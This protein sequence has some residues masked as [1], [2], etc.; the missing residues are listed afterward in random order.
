MS[1]SNKRSNLYNSGI[2]SLIFER[3]EPLTRGDI[4]MAVKNNYHWTERLQEEADGG[5]APA[6][7]IR[8]PLCRRNAE[9]HRLRTDADDLPGPVGHA[10]VGSAGAHS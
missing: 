9:I 6:R 8:F 2:R 7:A 4:I 1:R 3:E 10:H 5:D